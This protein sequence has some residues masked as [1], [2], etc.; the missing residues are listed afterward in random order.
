MINI[1]KE[2]YELTKEFVTINSPKE[3]YIFVAGVWISGL[4]IG[5]LLG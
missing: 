3:V 4:V 2:V 5:V 1:I